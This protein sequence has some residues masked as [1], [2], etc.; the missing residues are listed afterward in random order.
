MRETRRQRRDREAREAA[1]GEGIAP[2]RIP[3]RPDGMTRQ[4]QRR[5]YRA[6]KKRWAGAV[7]NQAAGRRQY[8]K[9]NATTQTNSDDST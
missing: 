5:L 7:K 1:R 9:N 6:D 3:A 8:L 4:E 2:L